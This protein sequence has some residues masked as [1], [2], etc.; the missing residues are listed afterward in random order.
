MASRVRSMIAAHT[1]R[2]QSPVG[3]VTIV[4]VGGLLGLVSYVYLAGFLGGPDAVTAEGAAAARRTAVA[5]SGVLV[6]TYLA[7]GFVRGLGGPLLN[8]GY[9]LLHLLFTPSVAVSLT[10]G[11]MPGDLVLAGP[12]LAVGTLVDVLVAVLVPLSTY[13]LAQALW[14]RHGRS[15]EER[16]AWVADHLPA[17][18]R[19]T[20]LDPSRFDRRLGDDGVG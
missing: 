4:V 16:V 14:F 11:S 8:L 2:D 7:V 3:H 5:L 12:L 15:P 19:G 13:V 18:Y 6:G 17:A 10:G 1:F 9:L 20:V